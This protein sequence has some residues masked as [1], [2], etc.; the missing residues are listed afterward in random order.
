VRPVRPSSIATNPS[1]PDGGTV[2]AGAEAR[3]DFGLGRE[4]VEWTTPEKPPQ[5]LPITPA[6]LLVGA[7]SRADHTALVTIGNPTDAPLA[8]RL[9]LRVVAAKLGGP[10]TVTDALTGAP[11]P[12]IDAQ[13]VLAVPANS[14]RMV[15]IEAVR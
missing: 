8:A 14:F 4:Q 5:W 11:C 1:L 3:R 6:A 13:M 9:D 7:Y 10:V 15:R 2:R 12:P